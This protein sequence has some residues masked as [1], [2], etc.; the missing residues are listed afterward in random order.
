MHLLIGVYSGQIYLEKRVKL[1]FIK[2]FVA[3]ALALFDCVDCISA[4]L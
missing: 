4:V 2:N 3:E 1:F